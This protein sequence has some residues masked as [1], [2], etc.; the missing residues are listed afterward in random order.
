VSETSPVG[1]IYVVEEK[2]DPYFEITAPF[3]EHQAMAVLR[4][5]CSELD[6]SVEIE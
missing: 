2:T 1:Q 3:L 6:H 5:V 4:L